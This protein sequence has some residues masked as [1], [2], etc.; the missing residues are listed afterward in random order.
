MVIFAAGWALLRLWAGVA[1]LG[2][3]LIL[4]GV[5]LGMGEKQPAAE[6]DEVA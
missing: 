6:P 3:E 4:M 5:A 1:V 2:L